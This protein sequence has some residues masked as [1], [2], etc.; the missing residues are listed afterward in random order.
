M[1]ILDALRFANNKLKQANVDSPMLDAEV[2]LADM[3]GITRA[4]LF[5]KF[6]D[7]LQP[8][9][10]EKF[11]S[12]I[13]RRCT[14]E[15]IAYLIGKKP[16]FGRDFSVNPF[17]LIPR[18]D[19]ELLVQQ[20]IELFETIN[21]KELTLFADIGTGSGAI[22][23]TL[24]AET[25][26]PVFA[27]D[28]SVRALAVA[29]QNAE[30]MGVADLIDFREGDLL[31]PLLQLF[32]TIRKTSLKPVSS[33]YPFKQLIICANLPYLAL[34]QMEQ[35]NRDVRAFE[36]HDALFAGP[37]GLEA[38]FRLFRQVKK[39]REG[40]PRHMWILSEIDPSQSERMERLAAHE[41][42]ASPLEIKQDLNGLDR[43]AILSV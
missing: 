29:K 20:A 35:L 24:A 36:P 10:Q 12:L 19:T 41:F 8:H 21:E 23:I 31:T 16:F 38:Y 6:S 4:K 17:V 28:T 27:S 37:D 3:L 11:I 13:E 26:A 22:A 9:E 1:T 34:S 18:P 7:Q 15:P 32:N 25:H 5:S 14:H 2:L 43:L 42:P 33:V 40:L 39:N 30:R